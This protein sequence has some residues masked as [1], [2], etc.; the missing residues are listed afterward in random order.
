MQIEKDVIR[1]LR[2][3]IEQELL[4]TA[5]ARRAAYQRMLAA[6]AVARVIGERPVRLRHRRVVLLDPAAHLGHEPV[7]QRLAVAQDGLREGILFIEIGA[8]VGSQRLGPLE[9]VL[10]IRRLEPGIVVADD[11]AVK[12]RR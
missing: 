1:A 7:A 9:D 10:P 6:V 8:D 5:F 11:A 2:V 4:G 12:G 3:T